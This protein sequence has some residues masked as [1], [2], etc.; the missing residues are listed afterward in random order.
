MV[1]SNLSRFAFAGVILLCSYAFQTLGAALSASTSSVTQPGSTPLTNS[2]VDPPSTSTVTALTGFPSGTPPP[3]IPMS[4]VFI[5]EDTLIKPNGTDKALENVKPVLPDKNVTIILPPPVNANNPGKFEDLHK[6]S[7]EEALPFLLDQYAIPHD[8]VKALID[9]GVPVLNDALL[10]LLSGGSNSTDLDAR[11]QARI[12]GLEKVVHWVEKAVD[13]VGDALGDAAKA[14]KN[15]VVNAAQDVGCGIFA[16]STLPGYL[17]YA[18]LFRVQN[19]FSTSY[20]TSQDQ[21]FYIYPLHGPISHNDNIR[22][23]YRA[24]FPPGFGNAAAVTMGRVIYTRESVSSRTYGDARFNAATKLLLHEF[25]HSKQYQALGYN[26][27]LFGLKYLFEYCK[28]RFP[29]SSFHFAFTSLG[30][31]KLNE[32]KN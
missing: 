21:D 13:E 6:Q 12:F 2:T 17:L 8:K 18:D 11:L 19:A 27:S 14:V 24:N 3:E 9:S 4:R 30:R 25:T 10:A 15:A 31:R 20:P 7:L 23:Y 16:S 29:T 1:R 26:L 22:V 5:A 28:V 32:K